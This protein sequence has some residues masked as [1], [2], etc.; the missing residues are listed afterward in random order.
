MAQWNQS[1]LI[2]RPSRIKMATV[3]WTMS[4]GVDC[5]KDFEDIS[6]SKALS[7]CGPYVMLKLAD[8]DRIRHLG[9]LN[10]SEF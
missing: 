5:V 7:F 10:A 2:G 9:V 8:L 1:S 6:L 3:H 4:L